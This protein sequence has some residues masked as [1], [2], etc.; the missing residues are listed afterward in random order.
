MDSDPTDR[1]LEVPCLGQPCR[2]G[3]LYDAVNKSFLPGI[4]L[5]NE[6]SIEK[7]ATRSNQTSSRYNF[8]TEDSASSKASFFEVEPKLALYTLAGQLSLEGSIKYLNDHKSSLRNIRSALFYQCT[9]HYSEL[10]LADL[11]VSKQVVS[12]S[13]ATH[14]VVGILYGAS[15]VFLFEQKA[16]HEEDY[17]EVTLAL[18]LAVKELPFASVGVGGEITFGMNKK[19]DTKNI[20]CKVYCEGFTPMAI[21]STYKEAIKTFKQLPSQTF[22]NVAIPQKVLLYPLKRLNIKVSP[23]AGPG[24]C[25]LQLV[26][27]AI[28]AIDD[29]QSK[30]LEVEDLY[31]R[32]KPSRDRGHQVS[33]V[34]MGS[35]YHCFPSVYQQLEKVYL[36]IRQYKYHLLKKIMFAIENESESNCSSA[37]KQVIQEHDESPF[38]NDKDNNYKFHSWIT[39][40]RKEVIVLQNCLKSVYSKGPSNRAR[41]PGFGLYDKVLILSLRVAAKDDPLMHKMPTCFDREDKRIP[42]Q[43]PAKWYMDP[44]NFLNL[45]QT[46]K[47]FLQC[48]KEEP[49]F[50]FSVEECDETNTVRANCDN[51]DGSKA[52]FFVENAQIAGIVIEEKRKRQCYKPN[53]H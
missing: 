34:E 27:N 25:F 14:V 36:S 42:S 44:H 53:V 11:S 45:K 28:D 13:N 12:T 26:N 37:L 24:K 38:S 30:E 52:C 32:T 16:S 1:S 20:S 39:D 41:V 50:L 9:T 17:H 47:Q 46:I 40:K 48:I 6:D 22:E 19:I 33:K 35:I 7:F 18:E 8:F 5:W 49:D 3:T 29:I 43:Q 4:T 31:S 23:A 21:P 15:A 10:S 51:C 2:M